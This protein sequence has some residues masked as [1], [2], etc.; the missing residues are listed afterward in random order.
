MKINHKKLS[1][2]YYRLERISD[3][4]DN[5]VY[6]GYFFSRANMIASYNKIIYPD[7]YCKVK[8]Y[9]KKKGRNK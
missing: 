9:L 7:F 1:I 5:L 4:S 3:M 2:V 6:G 8:R